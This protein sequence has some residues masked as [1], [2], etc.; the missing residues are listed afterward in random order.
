VD[1]LPADLE[2]ILAQ[3]HD[4]L[5][6]IR[7]ETFS[8]AYLATLAEIEQLPCNQSGQDSHGSFALRSASMSSSRARVSFAEERP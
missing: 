2:R 8:S 4:E 6:G 7:P 3:L 1:D 5:G